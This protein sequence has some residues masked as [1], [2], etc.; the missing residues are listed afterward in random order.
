MTTNSDLLYKA[1]NIKFII[2]GESYTREDVANSDLLFK[3]DSLKIII[4]GQSFTRT[5]VEGSNLILTSNN[6]EYVLKAEDLIPPTNS[7]MRQIYSDGNHTYGA[8]N[9][10]LVVF[11]L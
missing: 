9:K 5:A 11:K 1:D 10:G 2:D 3:S 8:T 4:A 7:V 6:I